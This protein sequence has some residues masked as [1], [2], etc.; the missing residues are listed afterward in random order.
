MVIADKKVVSLSYQ[1]RE[2][3]ASGEVIE[4]VTAD[5]PLVFLY[6]A[7]NLLPK[8]EENISG[9]SVGDDFSFRLKAEEAYGEVEE[10]AVVKV[11][12]SAFASSDGE[13]DPDL[14]VVG[15]MIPMLDHLGNRLE[16]VII[17]IGDDAVVMD[18]NHPL[19]G[20]DLF[21]SGK[22][23]EVRDASAEELTHGHVHGAGG[24][25]GGCDSDSDSDSNCN[26]GG[27]SGCGCSE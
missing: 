13:I 9:L 19:A 7:G 22:V 11:P 16:G 26:S 27:C 14:L 23:V 15:N 20:D 18:F 4:T 17:E 25:Q 10:D 5:R 12:K 24:C 21:F 1:L 2:G 8:F 3:D 6:G